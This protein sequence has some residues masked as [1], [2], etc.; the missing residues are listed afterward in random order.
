MCQ[1]RKARLYDHLIYPLLLHIV[2][3][4]TCVSAACEHK[5]HSPMIAPPN[6]APAAPKLDRRRAI[7]T[8]NLDSE[9]K[10]RQAFTRCPL[11]YRMQTDTEQ[12]WDSGGL[13]A[14]SL[15]FL[16]IQVV[17]YAVC[18]LTCFPCSFPLVQACERCEPC[19]PGLDHKWPCRQGLHNYPR[20]A[21]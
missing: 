19:R 17:V 11:L 6:Q 16:F 3:P 10:V 8:L 15:V 12:R 1:E 7:G 21:C 20:L 13:G 4:F 5:R 9:K 18:S 2:S 14:S